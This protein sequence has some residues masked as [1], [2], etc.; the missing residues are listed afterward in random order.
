MRAE[1]ARA[2]LAAAVATFVTLG[3]APQ[4]RAFCRTSTCPLP[5]DFAPSASACEPAGFAQYCANLNQPVSPRPI[6]WRNACQS[7]DIQQD[8]SR[9]VPYD[10]AVQSFATAFSKWTGASCPG[11]GHPSLEAQNLGPVECAEVHFNDSSTGQGNQHVIVFRDHGWPH[12]SDLNNTL[13]L[14]TITF[15]PESGEIYDADMEINS[16]VT[17]TVAGPVPPAGDDFMSI[18]THEVGHFFGMAHSGNSLATM[19]AHYTPGSTHMRDLTSDDTAGI[20]A[21]YP[22]GGDRAVDPAVADGGLIQEDSC[23]PTPRHGF[24]SACTQAPGKSGCAVGAVRSPTSPAG[25]AW[26]AA[27]ALAAAVA[28]RRLRRSARR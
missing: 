19:F 2:A 23:D 22:P 13:G 9:Q 15:D 25:P 1:I 8:A 6:W 27:A 24:Q 3:A 11:G 5:A 17:L 4:A 18:I 16:T 28:S 7:Y 14:T 10:V 12:P 26:L 20:C 21:I